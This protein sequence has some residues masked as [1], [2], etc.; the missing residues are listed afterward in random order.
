MFHLFF[1]VCCNC[2]YLNVAYVSH[3]CCKCFIWMLCVCND[4]QVI[5][6]SV[7][8]ACFKCFICLQI[9]VASVVSECFKS[10]S[11]VAHGMRTREMD[12]PGPR[13]HS[14][15]RYPIGRPGTGS[16]VS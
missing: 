6:A 8:D 4:F 5:F 11:S 7:S 13:Y 10:R 14:T 16:S 3:I 12:R 2:V 15:D 9:Y 1:D